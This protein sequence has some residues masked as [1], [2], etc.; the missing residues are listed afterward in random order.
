M[1][2]IQFSLYHSHHQTHTHITPQESLVNYFVCCLDFIKH[3]LCAYFV[4]ASGFLPLYIL[5]TLNNIQDM[6]TP[7]TQA[8][9]EK[10]RCFEELN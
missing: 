9:R 2:V 5:Y 1:N 6:N 7:I 3:L 4:L 10:W 8:W